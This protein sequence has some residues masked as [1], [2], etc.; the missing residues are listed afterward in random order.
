MTDLTKQNETALVI[1]KEFQGFTEAEIMGGMNP[2]QE[3]YLKSFKYFLSRPT[4]KD[5]FKIVNNE[6]DETVWEG[7]EIKGAVIYYGHEILRL[8]RGYVESLNKNEV[9]F[10]D[11]ENEIL[12]VTYD[13][14]NSRG[15][16]D[17]NGYGAYLTKEHAEIQG[18]MRRLYLIMTLPG[19]EYGTGLDLVAASFSVTTIKSFNAL[20]KV[21]KGYNLPLPILRTNI[22]FSEAKSKSDQEYDRVDFGLAKKEDGSVL[23][24]HKS[25][26]AYKTSPYGVKMLED[27]ILTHKGAVENTE[28]SGFGTAVTEKEIPSSGQEFAESLKESFKGTD[29]DPNSDEMP[30]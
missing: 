20:R 9:D 22:F 13:A 11:E 29:I 10:T 23:F 19:K 25:A 2:I 15:N 8:K 4:M 18:K 28:R 24:S 17:A 7:S 30:F 16:F 5:K 14:H 27:I 6:T 12:A 21:V 26:D 3:G 1:P